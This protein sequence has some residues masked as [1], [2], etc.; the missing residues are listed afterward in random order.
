MC[1]FIIS[2]PFY[3][4]LAPIRYLIWKRYR[5]FREWACLNVHSFPFYWI[6]ALIQDL[7]WHQYRNIGKWT[8]PNIPTAY[9]YS[10]LQIHV[11]ILILVHVER[12]K[13]VVATGEVINKS[14]FQNAKFTWQWNILNKKLLKN[15][16]SE[17]LSG[18]WLFV[19][20]LEDESTM[21]L[22]N[23]RICL[24]TAERHTP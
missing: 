13:N 8:C 19:C 5:I 9:T 11:F 24:L 2:F 17:S 6:L 14:A 22:Q 3:W 18:T 23:V 16:L 7:I 4:F 21:I 12:Y 20:D 1:V 10:R 15:A